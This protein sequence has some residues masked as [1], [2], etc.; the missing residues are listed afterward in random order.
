MVFKKLFQ[1]RRSK[2]AAKEDKTKELSVVT[3]GPE[4]VVRHGMFSNAALASAFCSL[5]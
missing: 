2:K 1:R 3:K 5:L 4:E